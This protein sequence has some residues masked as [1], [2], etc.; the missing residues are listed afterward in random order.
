MSKLNT[1]S[2]RRNTSTPP[3]YSMSGNGGYPSLPMDLSTLNTNF[4]NFMGQE[5]FI[6]SFAGIDGYTQSAYLQ[7]ISPLSFNTDGMNAETPGAKWLGEGNILQTGAQGL[8]AIAGLGQAYTGYKQ[9]GLAEDQ[10]DFSRDAFKVNTNNQ[11]AGI[12]ANIAQKYETMFRGQ[13][14][15]DSQSMA[16]NKA[17]ELT[18][19][20]KGV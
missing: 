16:N 19:E 5:S 8:Q 11:L 14:F 1:L 9:L 17:N 12:R 3:N 10:L 15:E 13:G 2:G 4:A 7:N 6:P 20:F 18:S